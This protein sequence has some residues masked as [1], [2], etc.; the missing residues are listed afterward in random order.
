MTAIGA[1]KPSCHRLAREGERGKSQVT[2]TQ[3]LPRDTQGSGWAVPD[4]PVHA[5]TND[6]SRNTTRFAA[7]WPAAICEASK[8]NNTKTSGWSAVSSGAVIWTWVPASAYP[9]GEG[10]TLA[11]SSIL[12][13][14]RLAIMSRVRAA[15]LFD[16]RSLDNE[17]RGWTGRA[18]R[19]DR[20]ELLDTPY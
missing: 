7:L 9:V 6:P 2:I 17:R 18:G 1:G 11:V 19:H 20:R 14:P 15:A 10:E 5:S 12:T 13:V 8:V 4:G 16:L 3:R